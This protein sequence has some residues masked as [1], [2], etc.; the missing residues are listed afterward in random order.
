MQHELNTQVVERASGINMIFG[1]NIMQCL[2]FS[3]SSMKY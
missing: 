1:M 3:S 2:S